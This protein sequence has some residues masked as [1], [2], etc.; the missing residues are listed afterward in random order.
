MSDREGAV[1]I[2]RAASA[3]SGGTTGPEPEHADLPLI[4]VIYGLHIQPTMKDLKGGHT[5]WYPLF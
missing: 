2:G 5:L 3:G 1:K 4:Y